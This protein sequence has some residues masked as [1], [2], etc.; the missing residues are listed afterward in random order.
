LANSRFFSLPLS[1]ISILQ[2]TLNLVSVS[3]Q[4]S[5]S[6]LFHIVFNDSTVSLF[7]SIFLMSVF[8]LFLSR[9]STL[10]GPNFGTVNPLLPT[11][12]FLPRI[13]ESK[14]TTKRFSEG[15]FCD[16]TLDS[17]LL[18]VTHILTHSYVYFLTHSH[19]HSKNRS[20]GKFPGNI[21]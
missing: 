17:Q 18:L 8:V 10:L 14:T 20:Y 3:Q 2:N 6:L 21:Y 12:S 5:I 1:R 11:R 15:E 4:S 7:P 9:I 19:C 13:N 16:P